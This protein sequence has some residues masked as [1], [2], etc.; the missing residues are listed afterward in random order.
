M[1]SV[2][3]KVAIE[4]A[5]SKLSP[6]DRDLV[7]LIYKYEL[8][9]GYGPT[10]PRNLAELGRLW[11]VKWFGVPFSEAAIRYKRDAIKDEWQGKRRNQNNRSKS[12]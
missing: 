6:E 8:P 5:L 3:N 7:N 10:F 9:D 12:K 1:D 2:I 4:Q 11:G